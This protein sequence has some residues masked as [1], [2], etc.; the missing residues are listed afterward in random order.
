MQAT[1]HPLWGAVYYGSPS[2]L[3]SR[4]KPRSVYA[5]PALHSSCS[6]YVYS[7]PSSSPSRTLLHLSFGHGHHCSRF[8]VGAP[9]S[10][11]T[12]TC[13]NMPRRTSNLLPSSAR[14]PV[15]LS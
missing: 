9:R 5:Q 14:F 15:C 3:T 2:L 10:A 11:P 13:A 1:V 6:D 4:S 12:T 7:I 8:F